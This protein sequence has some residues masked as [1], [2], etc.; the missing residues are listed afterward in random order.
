MNKESGETKTVTHGF[1]ESFIVRQAVPNHIIIRDFF[2]DDGNETVGIFCDDQTGGGVQRQKCAV[3]CAIIP[4]G[5]GG[6]T[7]DA[8]VCGVE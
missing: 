6:Q 1:Q 4:L 3:L 2:D 5:I 8:Q 7:V